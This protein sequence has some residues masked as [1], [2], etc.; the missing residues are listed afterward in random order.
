MLIQNVMMLNLN[1]NLP[2]KQI[3]DK[4]FL[5][6]FLND[7]EIF[8]NPSII[9]VSVECLKSNKTGEVHV[10]DNVWCNKK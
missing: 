8:L 5:N 4:D 9:T 10:S 7:F 2:L 1:E 6:N 3:K